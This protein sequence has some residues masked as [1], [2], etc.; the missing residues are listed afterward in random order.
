L[1]SGVVIAAFDFNGACGAVRRRRRG[2][3]VIFL[4]QKNWITFGARIIIV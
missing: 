1:I 4:L 3:V 2:G